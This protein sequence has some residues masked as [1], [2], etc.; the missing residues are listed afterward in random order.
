M[1]VMHNLLNIETTLERI[2]VSLEKI[3][4][5]PINC[6]VEAKNEKPKK[7]KQKMD[8]D[9]ELDELIAVATEYVLLEEGNEEQL[10]NEVLVRYNVTSFANLSCDEMCELRQNLRIQLDKNKKE[11][12]IGKG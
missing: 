6:A 2:A 1:D 3:S 5:T 11:Q 12:K 4:E 10:K 7:G 9:F 8:R